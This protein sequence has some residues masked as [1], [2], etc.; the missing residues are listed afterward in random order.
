MLVT[1]VYSNINTKQK[2]IYGR[3]QQTNYVEIL[4]YYYNSGGNFVDTYDRLT[5]PMLF[6]FMTVTASSAGN[7]QKEQS[8][9][10][11]SE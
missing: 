7:Y 5:C 6:H 8:E 9:T 1:A 2:A 10:W 11:I 4:D 3:M